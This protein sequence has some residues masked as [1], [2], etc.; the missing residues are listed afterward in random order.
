MPHPLSFSFS[1]NT[2][3]DDHYATLG[4]S[5]RSATPELIKRAY[6]EKA[7]VTH[8]DLHPTDPT[9]KA[10]FQKVNQ[11]YQILKDPEKKAHYDLYGTEQ[12]DTG[13]GQDEWHAEAWK[14]AWH[15]YGFDHYLNALKEDALD[16]VD[17]IRYR[18]DWHLAQRFASK[19][20]IVAVGGVR[21][22]CARAA[23]PAADL[24][25]VAL[26]VYHCWNDVHAFATS[27]TTN[28]YEPN[29]DVGQTQHDDAWW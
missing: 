6:F 29:M 26:G 10:Q 18:N 8:P 16:A 17:D 27:P 20:Q 13:A 7:K 25:G 2:N 21:S 24:G 1:T 22:L 23:V 14:D 28:D 15:T 12:P 9:S 4:L 11:A 19:K 3:E 5:N